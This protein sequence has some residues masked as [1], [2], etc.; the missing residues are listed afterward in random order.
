MKQG[1]GKIRASPAT[2]GYL[3]KSLRCTYGY[4]VTHDPS[5]SSQV[6]EMREPVRVKSVNV[7]T[8]GE[9]L[10]V[11]AADYIIVD[12]IFQVLRVTKLVF[13]SNGKLDGLFNVDKAVRWVFL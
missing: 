9:L 4:F 2:F 1:R 5:L 7:I 11:K 10:H 6:A 8:P 3:D 12:E 13:G